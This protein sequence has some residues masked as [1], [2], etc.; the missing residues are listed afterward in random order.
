MWYQYTTICLSVPPNPLYGTQYV[1]QSLLCTT[2]LYYRTL[3]VAYS[4]CIAIPLH[5]TLYHQA[6]YTHCYDVPHYMQ[7]YHYVYT[8]MY[9]AIPKATAAL[10][11]D[12]CKKWHWWQCNATVQC[13][14]HNYMAFSNEIDGAKCVLCPLTATI[15]CVDCT[16]QAQAFCTLQSVRC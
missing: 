13:R 12:N 16:S 4:M 10:C 14:I 11:T 3:Y 8:T 9:H 7:L 2:T 15:K 6:H 1:L 5:A